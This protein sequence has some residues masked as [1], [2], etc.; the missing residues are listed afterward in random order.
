M[1]DDRFVEDTVAIILEKE[2]RDALDAW[3]T[4]VSEIKND[5]GL[6]KRIHNHVGKHL[7]HQIEKTFRSARR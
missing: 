5:V 3:T 4:A 1:S 2:G 6:V 7:A